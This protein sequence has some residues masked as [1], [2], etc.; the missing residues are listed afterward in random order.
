MKKK[1][2]GLVVLVLILSLLLVSSVLAAGTNTQQSKTGGGFNVMNKLEGISNKIIVIGNLNWLGLSDKKVV[3]GL[4]R[5][6][7][8]ILMFTLFFAILNGFAGTSGSLGFLKKNHA[9]VIAFVLASISAIFMPTAALLAIGSG[10]ATA[11]ALL[12]IGGPIVGLGF[13]LWKIP[14]DDEETRGSVFLK[15]VLCLILFWILAAVEFHL[16]ALKVL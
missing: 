3:T 16:K 1:W 9:V 5:I 12:L 14:F 11:V 13:L 2:I 10:W 8:L 4:T 15:L 6:L 7:I